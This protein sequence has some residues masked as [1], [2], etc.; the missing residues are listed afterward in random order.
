MET[1]FAGSTCNDVVT[2]TSGFTFIS[3]HYD[4]KIRFWDVRADNTAK[5]LVFQG[6]ITSLDLSRGKLAQV[7]KRASPNV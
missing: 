1:K 4:K 5:E 6:R 3:G 2:D 7:W